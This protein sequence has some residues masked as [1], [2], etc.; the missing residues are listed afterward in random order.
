MEN[1]CRGWAEEGGLCTPQ[2]IKLLSNAAAVALAVTLFYFT[3]VARKHLV[4]FW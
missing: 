3:T 1:Y 4:R 2:F